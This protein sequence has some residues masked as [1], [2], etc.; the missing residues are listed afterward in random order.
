MKK[1]SELTSEEAD[2][3]LKA[4]FND[5]TVPMNTAILLALNKQTAGVEENAEQSGGTALVENCAEKQ[6][7]VLLKKKNKSTRRNKKR[8][9]IKP[10]TEQSKQNEN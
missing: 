7:S 8:S 5:P 6:T 3:H 2:Q 4:W 9:K 1:F 10:L